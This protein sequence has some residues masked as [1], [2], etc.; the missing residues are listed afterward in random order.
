VLA[1]RVFSRKSPITGALVFAEV[2]LRN[3]RMANA[4][5]ERDILAACS[6]RLASHM[7][8]AGLRFVADLPMTDGGKL[9]RHG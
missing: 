7:V 9:A 1:S 5:C 8:P 3:G 4:A 6:A 2:V